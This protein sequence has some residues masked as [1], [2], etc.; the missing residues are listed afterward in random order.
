MLVFAERLQ[1][2]QTLFF[3]IH[4]LVR[5]VGNIKTVKTILKNGLSPHRQRPLLVGRYVLDGA[6]YND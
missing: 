3:D 5:V 2:W 1:N 6:Q 4:K